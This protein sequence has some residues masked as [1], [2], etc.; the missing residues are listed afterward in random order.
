VG[1]GFKDDC[2]ARWDAHSTGRNANA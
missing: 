2:D 1:D